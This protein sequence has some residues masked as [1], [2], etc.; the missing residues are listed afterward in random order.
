MKGLRI[1]VFGLGRSGLAVARAAKQLGADPIVF[2]EKPADLIAKQDVLVEAMA[3]G[4]RLELGWQGDFNGVDLLVSNPAVN[5]RHPKLLA[6][7]S[8]GVEI[9][10]EVEF[11]YRI[12]KAPIIAITGTNG[13]STTTVMTALALRSAGKDAVLCGNIF[14]SG[15]DEVPL[16]DA[17]LASTPDQ[18]LVAEISSFQLEWV[19][20]FR[21]V[22]AG[23][24]NIT[25][26]HLDRYLNREEYAATKRRIFAAQTAEDLAVINAD[27]DEIAHLPAGPK[28]AT[29]G[30]NGKDARLTSTHIEILGHSIKTSELGVIGMHNYANAAMALLLASK[31]INPS[32]MEA[33]IE[34]LKQFKGIAHRLQVVGD[35]DGVT[36]INNSMCTN[37]D[38]VVKSLEAVGR[39]TRVLVGGANK[40]LPFDRLAD[41]LQG[42]QH[43]VFL[44]GSARA[45]LNR[46]LG[47]CWPAVETLPEAF[48][49][50]VQSI[51]PGEVVMLAPGC[52]SMDQ[53]K[54]FR[55]RGDVFVSMAKEWLTR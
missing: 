20:A 18:V 39:P 40:D 53:F 44:F 8:D 42:Q 25:E 16:T 9:I 24:T 47:G 35:R 49:L 5:K 46:M 37:P 14:G 36:F 41:Y 4:V 13:K 3:L 2:D 28:I 1:G 51:R 7:E 34:G 43:S 17:A 22:S 48:H 30:I 33:A 55:E 23:I 45:E 10:S 50:A 12:A 31:V 11:A 38:A 54:D 21:P 26:D 15:F 19:S 52:A 29:F 32:Q 27:T 6:A